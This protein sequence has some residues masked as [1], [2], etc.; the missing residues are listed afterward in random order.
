MKIVIESQRVVPPDRK[1]LSLIVFCNSA[2]QRDGKTENG[3]IV[4]ALL[5]TEG[6]LRWELTTFMSGM[7]MRNLLYEEIW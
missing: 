2:I 3:R 5:H 4:P 7:P 6:Y 1:R